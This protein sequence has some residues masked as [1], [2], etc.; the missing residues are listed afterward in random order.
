MYILRNRERYINKIKCTPI[1]LC[2]N[3]PYREM[4]KVFDISYRI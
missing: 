4:K 3:I 1:S 2:L